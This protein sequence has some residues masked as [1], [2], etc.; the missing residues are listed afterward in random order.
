MFILLLR[1]DKEL[2]RSAANRDRKVAGL[3]DRH[4]AHVGQEPARRQESDTSREREAG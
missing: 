1:L 2:E 3:V 4:Q